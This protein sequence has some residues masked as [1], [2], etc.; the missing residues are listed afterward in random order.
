MPLAVPIAVPQLWL[1]WA[2]ALAFFALVLRAITRRKD[3]A[4]SRSDP[5]S[6]LGI[7]V[8][9]IGIGLSAAG[10]VKATLPPFSLP[11]I[12]AYLAVVLLMGTAIALFASSSSALGKNWSFEARTR[13]DHQLVRSGPYA[14]IRH[15][16]YLGMLFFLL[17]L[18]VATGHWAQP[19]LALPVFLAGTRIRTKL[20]D[21]LLE[22]QFGAEF[23]DYART[24]PALIP[25]LL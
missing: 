18:A 6:R 1:F 10:P 4:G 11:A 25:R 20:E 8:Q 5:R 7:I 22:R 9:S 14:R 19:L 21:E 23:A 12:A 16:I 2:F 13:S 3:E 24:T 17:G 15:P